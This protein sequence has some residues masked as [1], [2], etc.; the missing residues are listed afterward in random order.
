MIAESFPAAGEYSTKSD[1]A[2][3]KSD[4]AALKSD[5]ADLRVDFHEHA[6]SIEARLA[7]TDRRIY[8]FGLAL[9]VP[10]WGAMVAALVKFVVQV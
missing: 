3:L 8:A 1:F 5:F 6:R 2:A 7:H 9:L 10:M 4:F